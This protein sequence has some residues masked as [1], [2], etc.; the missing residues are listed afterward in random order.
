M[1]PLRLDV[2]PK[3]APAHSL[4]PGAIEFLNH[5]RFVSMTCRA[6]RRTDLFE[7]CALLHVHRARTLE[8]HADALM[9]C[10]NEALEKRAQL[11]APGSAEISFDES[12]L[13][14]L[15]TACAQD[16]AMSRRFLLQSRVAHEH[17]RL[18]AFLMQRVSE[19]FS[20]N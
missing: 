4:T 12:W 20:L 5:L 15:G 10:L 13:V 17:Q 18:V 6:K 19:Y 16:D 8:A 11:Y 14:Q 2:A 7:A 1:I 3:A 9:R